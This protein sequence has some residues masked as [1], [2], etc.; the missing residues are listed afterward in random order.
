MGGVL[1]T[2]AGVGGVSALVELQAVASGQTQPS[3][4][5]DPDVVAAQKRVQDAQAAYDQA[6]AAAQCELVGS[7]GTHTP[8]VGEAYRQAKAK[9]DQAKAALEEA[10]G[11]L[12]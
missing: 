1:L 10:K 5:G 6:D 8:G 12:T 7:C 9:A 4:S 11:Q 3:V 2:T